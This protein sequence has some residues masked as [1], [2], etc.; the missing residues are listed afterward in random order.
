[1]SQDEVSRREAL[2]AG[3]AGVGLAAAGSVLGAACAPEGEAPSDAAAPAGAGTQTGPRVVVIGAGAFGGWTALWLQRGGARVTLVDAWGPGNSRASSGG[4]SRVIR[5]NYGANG[6]YTDLVIRS[7]ALWREH[8][9]EWG[10]RIYTQNGMIWMT[11][12]QTERARSAVQVFEER[13][14][15]FEEMDGPEVARRFPAIRPDGIGYALY[16]EDAGFLLA[17]RGCQRVLETFLAAGGVYRQAHATPGAMDG[18]A[19]GEVRLADGDRLEADLFVFAGGP[20]LAELFPGFDPPLVAPTRQE[21]LYFGTPPGRSDLTDAELPAWIQSGSGFYGIPGNEHRGFKIADDR[22][23]ASFDPTN[24]DR[25]PSEKAIREAREFVE[26]RFPALAGAPLVEAR[27]CQ[28]EQSADGNVI[29]DTHPDADNAWILG[30]GS[31]HGFKFGP[32]LGEMVAA[33]VL[34]QREKE[35]FFSLARFATA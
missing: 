24:G 21:V 2:T 1:M 35:P 15:A 4:E 32:A 3:L 6:I 22:R 8:Q 11:G 17:R 25:T 7:L 28:Y 27:V 34:G 33:Q 30:G 18:G 5:A 14:V 16:E 26:H 20:W 10:D 29:A 12:E 31:G 13:G 9:E 23:G 19:M